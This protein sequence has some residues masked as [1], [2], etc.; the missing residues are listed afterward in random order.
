MK[1]KIAIIACLCM[2]F[3]AFPGKVNADDLG[4]TMTDGKCPVCGSKMVCTFASSKGCD[5][6]CRNPECAYVN[7]NGVGYKV[8][9]KHDLVYTENG[10]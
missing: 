3:I 1:R 10:K 4:K 7:E 5:W 8:S 2:M 6:E 9:T